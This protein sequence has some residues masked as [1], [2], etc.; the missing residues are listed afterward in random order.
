MQQLST[1]G[2]SPFVLFFWSC[3][4]ANLDIDT[5]A[6]TAPIPWSWPMTLVARAATSPAPPITAVILALPGALVVVLLAGTPLLLVR[7]LTFLGRSIFLG[8][9]SCDDIF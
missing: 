1:D 3:S 2:V 4:L 5:G 6:A 7:K 9:G 8:I